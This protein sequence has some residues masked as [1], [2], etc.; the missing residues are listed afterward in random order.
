MDATSRNVG[1][2]ER[3]VMLAA[4]AALLGYAWRHRS[5]RLGLTSAGLLAR[6]ATGFCPAYAALGVNHADTK[7]ALGGDRG[8]HVRESITVDATPEELYTFWRRYENL[9]HLMPHLERVEAIDAK[10]SRWT[11]KALG[12]VTVSWLAE[13]INEVPYE[14][15]GW[16][17]LPGEPIQHAGSVVFK[18]VPESGATDVRVHFQYAPPGGKAAAWFTAFLGQDPAKAT[19]EGLQALKERFVPRMRA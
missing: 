13:T 3:L 7:H 8:I 15:I 2:M 10:L 18:P 19:R 6:G 1:N 17:T 9:P 14:T 4:G 5:R 16:K 11:A 12:G